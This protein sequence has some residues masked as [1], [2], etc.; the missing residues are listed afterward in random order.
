MITQFPPKSKREVEMIGQLKSYITTKHVRNIFIYFLNNITT[1]KYITNAKSSKDIAEYIGIPSTRKEFK[2]AL[3]FLNKLGLTQK[4][5]GFYAIHPAIES[6]AIGVQH[7]HNLYDYYLN[8]YDP[9]VIQHL[10]IP[11]LDNLKREALMEYMINGQSSMSKQEKEE[12]M[13]DYRELHGGN[14]FEDNET[15]LFSEELFEQRYNLIYSGE[16][17]PPNYKAF[18]RGVQTPYKNLLRKWLIVLTE[19][20]ID[21]LAEQEVLTV[22]PEGIEYHAISPSK[23]NSVKS[24]KET[25]MILNLTVEQSVNQLVDN[26]FEEQE[27]I[28]ATQ[29]L[30]LEET[31][32]AH[33]TA[34]PFKL[35]PA[36]LA[37]D[38]QKKYGINPN[39]KSIEDFDTPPFC[40]FEQITY[41]NTI[42]RSAHSLHQQILNIKRTLNTPA[43][44]LK[45]TIFEKSNT[46]YYSPLSPI[47]DNILKRKSDEW[48]HHKTNLQSLQQDLPNLERKLMSLYKEYAANNYKSLI[49]WL[50]H[51]QE[52]YN[53]NYTP[54]TDEDD[55]IRLPRIRK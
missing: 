18:K 36:S 37:T 31:K 53:S 38:R 54:S 16:A 44:E 40:S 29:E 23:F 25:S 39:W 45:D 14:F 34:Q 43:S 5:D 48:E 12:L 17:V 35:I 21:L 22:H 30:D 11:S 41:R 19:F 51:L 1:K 24:F 2:S 49:Q 47:P 6:Y 33:D 50:I 13:I 52:Q 27:R 46:L 26:C 55:N 4:V 8:L 20:H 7:L 15:V 28:D 32:T 42:E 9:K 10:S 3:S